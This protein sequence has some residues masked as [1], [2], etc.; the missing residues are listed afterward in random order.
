MD[1]TRLD[2]YKAD[3]V[4]AAVDVRN[5]ARAVDMPVL[6][7]T[8]ET[9][10]GGW[11]R[12][13]WDGEAPYAW[14]G[15]VGGAAVAVLH[16]EAGTYDNTHLAWVDVTVHP[17]HRR[18]GYGSALH[19][20]GADYARRE[21]GRTT[22][23]LEGWDNPASRSFAAANGYEPK[24][25]EAIRRQT[26]A[27]VNPDA[28]AALRSDAEKAALDYEL[29]RMP[30]RTP[31]ELID[32]MANLVAAI[33]DAPRARLDLEDEVF[34]AERIRGYETACEA[35]GLRLYRVLARH[36]G[37]G[38]LAGNTAVAVEADRPAIGEQ[39]DTSV[40]GRHRGHRL[41]LMLKI[42]MM[43]WLAEVEPQ[44][45]T[46]DTGNE[47][48]NAFMIDVNEKLGYRLIAREILF[49]PTSPGDQD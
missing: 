36:R 40:V 46:I 28:V 27:D 25:T 8:A 14:L 29:I 23:G 48:N 5:A 20:F 4:R 10:Y 41:G 16:V 26:L 42:E 47:E 32:P 17:E 24:Y 6:H 3:D 1:V 33:N 19:D 11:L 45:E 7:P 13:G 21:L 44:L 18:R 37:T 38:E 49:Q 43:A 34:T 15:R 22:I 30:G 31:D 35:Q 12:L 39:H 2:P 9:A